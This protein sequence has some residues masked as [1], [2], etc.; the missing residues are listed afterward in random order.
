MAEHPSRTELIGRQ[1]PLTHLREAVEL[2][3]QGR[4]TTALVAGPAGIG[5]TSLV[6][7]ALVGLDVRVGWGTCVAEAPG[8][9]PWTQMLA[10]LV[11]AMGVSEAAEL[12]GD[13]APLL[14]T[15][16]PAL[17]EPSPGE[18][19]DRERLLLMD[20]TSRFLDAVAST[21]PLVVVLDDLQ[22]ADRSSLVLLDFVARG[23][24]PAGLGLVGTYRQDE[25]TPAARRH[26]GLIASHGHHVEL[27]GLDVDDVQELLR[28]VAGDPVDRATA[29]AVHRRTGGHPFYVRELALAGSLDR[30]DDG[31][32]PEAVRE[33]L[34]RSVGRLP[35]ATRAV[36]EVAA[37]A[38]P[39]LQVDVVATALA[40]TA[41]AVD[42]ATGPAID[43][44][45]LSV[46]RGRTRFTHDLWREAIVGTLDPVRRTGLHRDIGAALEDRAARN[47]QTTPSE[48]A[49]HFIAAIAA[50]GPARAVRWAL[51]AAA[52]DCAVLAFEDAAAQLRRLRAAITDAVTPLDDPTMVDVL[53]AEADAHARA[54]GT[55]D[56]RGL[57]RSAGELAGRSGDALRTAR[58]ALAMAQLGAR[59]SAR[60]DDIISALDR[61]LAI[62]H[63]S[64]DEPEME[65]QLMAAL[66]RELQ[67]SVAADRPRAGPLSERALALGRQATD[68]TTLVACLLARHDVLWTPGT[69][70]ERVEIAEE[71]AA[72]ALATGDR[73][74]HADGLLLLANAQLE[75]GSAAFRASLD[76]CLE[77]L[78]ELAHPRHRYLA[79]TR[80]AFDMLLRGDLVAAEAAIEEAAALGARIREPDTGNVRMSQ[81]LELVRARNDAEELRAFAKAAVEHWTGAP[82]H[83]HGVAAGFYARA[84]DLDAATA[85]VAT[86]VD[87]GTWR[88]DRSYLWSVFV[89]E[90]AQAAIAIE[91]PSLCADLLDDVSPLAGSCGVNG[92]VVAFAGSHSQTAGLLSTALDRPDAARVHLEQAATTYQRLG[93][94]SWLAEVRTSL[95]SSTS[96]GSLRVTSASMCREGDG[97]RIAFAGREAF[98]SHSKGMADL[99]RLLGSPGVEIHVLDLVGAPDRFGATE[100]MVDREALGSY[101]DRLRDLDGEIDEASTHNDPERSARLTVE[102]EALLAELGRVTGASGRPRTFANHPAERARKAVSAR[103]RDAIRRLEP[104]LPELAGHLE[105]RIVTGTYCRYR[106]VDA[107]AWRVD[108]RSGRG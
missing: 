37:L 89:R 62:V 44:A 82:I 101:R 28:R 48:L 20:A 88:A 79:D 63:A 51:A 56:A 77:L 13:D 17:G 46:D 85:H 15:I 69:A 41:V 55:L 39:E 2:A 68:P 3:T 11:H 50:D 60:R 59:F 24:G 31:R 74:R 81:R 99:A 97:W 105:P 14:A 91:D 10:G 38:G 65:A 93:A 7:A 52:S 49:R 26:L 78:D 66:A 35:V 92:A 87:L 72:V 9:W 108:S 33:V 107:P 4:R 64:G 43:A 29:D 76:H 58:V 40:V 32:L 30:L 80:R 57:L 83:A 36:L 75:Q 21:G 22:W 12:A 95:G 71:I 90:L 103:L 106:A 86:V 34:D 53:L 94:D 27:G 23:P 16:V 6:Q 18:A 104:T 1:R 47:G 67:H 42:V 45:I 61:A 8:Y 98:V 102:R 84:G 25:L 96:P 5:K 100:P 70:A 54:G 73:E 19:S